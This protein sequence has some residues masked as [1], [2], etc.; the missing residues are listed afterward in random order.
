MGGSVGGVCPACAIGAASRSGR[1]A[2]IEGDLEEVT[3][4]GLWDEDG[5]VAG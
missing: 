3:G 2:V 1:W 5:A 4:L